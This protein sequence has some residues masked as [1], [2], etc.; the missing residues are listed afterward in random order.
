MRSWFG[1]AES[2]GMEDALRARVRRRRGRR[3][4]AEGAVGGA[5]RRASTS[6]WTAPT[7]TNDEILARLD[8]RRHRRPARRRAAR[9]RRAAVRRRR[10]PHSGPREV[11]DV[12]DLPLAHARGRDAGDAPARRGDRAPA[13]RGHVHVLVR[14]AQRVR[15]QPPTRHALAAAFDDDV[16]AV[17][18][19]PVT[20]D[21]LRA[22]RGRAGSSSRSGP[23]SGRWS[24]PS[25][26]CLEERA[27]HAAPRRHVAVRWQGTGADRRR[28]HARSS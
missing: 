22:V 15:A 6:T 23:A 20:A 25:P 17:A 27:P 21:A 1:A 5:R 28:R 14:R 3:S 26:G 13:R 7:E 10:S 11:V 4:R 12:P 24:T 19:G 16:L 18:V 9:R 2:V 8:R